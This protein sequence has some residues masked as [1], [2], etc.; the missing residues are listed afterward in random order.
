MISLISMQC[1]SKD[2]RAT[3]GSIYIHW[4]GLLNCLKACMCTKFWESLWNQ[5]SENS[6][7]QMKLPFIGQMLPVDSSLTYSNL[8]S[9]HVKEQCVYV[10]VHTYCTVDINDIPTGPPPSLPPRRPSSTSSDILQQIPPSKPYSFFI[11]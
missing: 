5:L 9:F 2:N 8:S 3:L 10:C 4:T 1:W 6:N 11:I 7:L